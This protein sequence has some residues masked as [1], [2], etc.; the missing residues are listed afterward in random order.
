MNK[1]QPNSLFYFIS[2]F[3]FCVVCTAEENFFEESM[4][5]KSSEQFDQAI[6]ELEL[7]LIHEPQ[8]IHALE[9]KALMLGW[10][11]K[12]SVSISTWKKVIALQPQNLKHKINLARVLFWSGNYKESIVYLDQV[13]LAEPNN[14][15]AIELRKKVATAKPKIETRYRIDVGGV[16]DNFSAVRD[17]ESST[18]LQAGM[19]VNSQTDAFLRFDNQ[20]QFKATDQALGVGAYHKLDSDWLFNADYTA[21]VKKPNFRAKTILNLGLENF[22]FNPVSFSLG[23]RSLEFV[24][25]SVSIIQPGIQWSDYGFTVQFKYGLSQN[26]DKTSTS[27]SQIKV[28]YSLTESTSVGL[29]YAVGEEALPPLAKARV[30]YSTFGVQHQFDDQHAVRLD[31]VQEDRINVY[32]HQSIGFSYAYKF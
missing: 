24:Q 9:Q 26:I 16:S 22:S 27:S 2:V 3:L 10:R 13:L 15:D 8:N 23:Y 5:Y 19:K 25:G 21:S 1:K 7:L 20:N 17:R 30:N 29:G 6:L 11:Q 14:N 4:K 18:F 28:D 32:K 31:Y 12:Y